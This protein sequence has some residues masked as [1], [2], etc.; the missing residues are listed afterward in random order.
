MEKSFEFH[1]E[2][3]PK[4]NVGDTVWYFREETG[5]YLSTKITCILAEIHNMSNWIDCSIRDF[6]MMCAGYKTETYPTWFENGR[7]YFHND[8]LWRSE[9]EIRESAKWYPIK[10]DHDWEAA[11]GNREEKSHLKS[12]L[13]PCCSDISCIRDVLL[14]CQKNGGIIERDRQMILLSL[15]SHAEIIEEGKANFPNVNSIFSEL[16]INEKS[17]EGY[18]DR[19][20]K[21]MGEEYGQNN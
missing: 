8:E 3:A 10:D 2:F 21:R 15:G 5:R 16:D 4:F 19:Y 12:E 11:I 6:G 20:M 18:V 13:A 14:K 1:P 7:Y 9:E 17:F